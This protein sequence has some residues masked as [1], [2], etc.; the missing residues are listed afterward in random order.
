MAMIIDIYYGLL[1]RGDSCQIKLIGHR[2]N[3]GAI[4]LI[5]LTDALSRRFG[6][7]GMRIQ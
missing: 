3:F 5:D 4:E 1:T 7:A 2:N 6:L